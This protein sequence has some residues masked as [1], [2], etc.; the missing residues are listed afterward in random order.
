MPALRARHAGAVGV[1]GLMARGAIQAGHALTL[2]A[3]DDVGEVSV[4]VVAL[5]RIV[6]RGVAVDTARVSQ[7]RVDL[8]PRGQA[9][10]AARCGRVAPAPASLLRGTRQYDDPRRE[11]DE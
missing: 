8:L 4:S 10:G 2:G 6:R 5:L 9:F 11:R 7:N 1:G 3:A